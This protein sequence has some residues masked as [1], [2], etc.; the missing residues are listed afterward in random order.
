MHNEERGPTDRQN[1]A[2]KE[3]GPYLVFEPL[4][5]G[6]M[7]MVHRAKK[8]GIAGFERGVALKRI[9]PHLSMDAQFVNSFVHEAKLASL[10][11]H[12]NIA[13][14]YDF[15]QIDNIYY[16]AMEHVEGIGVKALIRYCHSHHCQL[17]MNVV[18]SILCEL[19]DALQYAHTYVDE[20]GQ[21]LGIVH[22]DV[23][24]SNL[25]LAQTGHLKVIDFGIAK[26][27]SRPLHTEPGQVQGKLSYM[28]PEAL[29]GRP[30]GPSSDVFSVGIV[31]HELL[32]AGRLFYATTDDE[33]VRRVLEF[34]IPPPSRKNPRIPAS[35]DRV[36]LAA[37]DRDE[38]RRLQSAG[39]FRKALDEVAREAG[40]RC[41]PSDVAEWWARGGAFNDH[42]GSRESPQSSSRIAAMRRSPRLVDPSG[43]QHQEHSTD[44][45]SRRLSV[46][47][48]EPLHGDPFAESGA[49]PP[50]SL[51]RLPG[52]LP[53]PVSALRSASSPAPSRFRTP[54]V[55]TLGVLCAIAA[56]FAVYQFAVR[57]T[58]VVAPGASTPT[59]AP[60]AP[61]LVKFIVQPP[62]S[63]VEIGG[64]KVSHASPFEVPLQ[65]GVHSIAV[66]R[67]GYKR[68]TSQIALHDPESQTVNVALEPEVAIVRVSSQP[69]GLVAELDGKPLDQVTPATV[70]TSPGPHTLVVVGA[71]GTWARDF[72]A[73]A[74][75]THA[76]HAV[77]APAKRS[78]SA[79][80]TSGVVRT[81]QASE[82]TPQRASSGNAAR[83]SAAREPVIEL[84]NHAIELGPEPSAVRPF[85]KA[86][87]PPTLAA[88]PA[89]TAVTSLPAPPP[90][91]RSSTPPL[92]P[93]TTVTK[94]SGEVPAIQSGN[95]SADVHS[96]ICIGTDGHVTSAKVIRANP[97]L[98]AEIERALLGWRYKPYRD[99]SGQPSPACFA[100]S[101][102]LIF[103][104]AHGG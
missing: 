58:A 37:L 95:G 60:S 26:A 84:D 79:A 75:E 102:R 73:A 87:P 39:E 47:S 91:P 63:I 17:P 48:A 44:R 28:S 77:L 92:V 23:S 24:P 33:I 2:V 70:E 34:E 100:V 74:D 85:A 30:V 62:D 10:L 49:Q 57:P 15:G 46:A 54:A 55:V 40:I 22:R 94:L 27:H 81:P 9:L 32:T 8:R 50:G 41:S 51:D 38:R 20:N 76:F 61:T 43:K 19:C 13:Q 101:F 88:Q 83:M 99:D 59:P 3:F 97:G 93:A 72:D 80:T 86:E 67:A 14:V 11:V 103:E 71:T 52:E 6:G 35:L 65:R 31:A 53:S 56:S 18:L 29:K 66:S 12:P 64:K 68:W 104:R 5:F 96:K 69:A 16:I 21:P 1:S 89:V 98:A 42:K 36:V 7:A 45:T 82:R 90:P 4:G 25:I 78:P